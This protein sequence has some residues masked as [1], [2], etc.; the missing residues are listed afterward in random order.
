M[1]KFIQNEPALLIKVNNEK[2]LLIS[3][4]H[5]GF[6][7]EL[8]SHGFNIPSQIDRIYNKLGN[9]L[10][11]YKPSRLIILGDVKHGTSKILPHEWSDIPNFFERLLTNVDK[12]DIIPGN[13]DG[14]LK[15]LLPSKVNL[16]TTKGLM[17]K[18]GKR[19]I[20][21]IH[22][23]S[24]PSPEAFTADILIMGH[25]HFVVE[26]MDTSG[27]RLIEPI[28]F[29]AKWDKEKIISSF[30]KSR[31]L[32]VGKNPINSF[33]KIFKFTPKNPR[34]IIMPTFNPLLR[35]MAVNKNTNKDYLGPIFESGAIDIENSELYLLDGTYLGYLSNIKHLSFE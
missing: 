32:K 35:G 11:I 6:E 4:L 27:L 12:I 21:L 14:S 7:K 8:Y 10:N 9:L 2:I 34:I 22:G 18:S 20:Y 16:H 3:D 19:L 31:R 25:H 30:L 5:L 17:L 26:I 33:K 23:H 15:T 1:L 29:V 28:W 13:H 24:W